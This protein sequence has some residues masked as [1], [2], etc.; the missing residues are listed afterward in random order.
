VYTLINV[1]SEHLFQLLESS[2]FPSVQHQSNIPV[3]LSIKKTW[4]GGNTLKNGEDPTREA[5][6]CVRVLGRVLVV[7][8]ENS[9]DDVVNE[10]HRSRVDSTGPTDAQLREHFADTLWQ[11]GGMSSLDGHRQEETS[12]EGTAAETDSSSLM[13]KLFK[14]TIDLLFCA[15]FTLPESAKGQSNDKINVSCVAHCS[16]LS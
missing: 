6:N 9:E 14:C 16:A 5:L 1:L 10:L 15:G 7:V 3:P 12:D 2:G 4:S 8:Y 13:E 11:S